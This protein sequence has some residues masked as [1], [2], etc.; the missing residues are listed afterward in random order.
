MHPPFSVYIFG[1]STNPF[2]TIK[3]RTIDGVD[4]PFYRDLVNPDDGDHYDPAA[5][6]VPDDYSLDVAPNHQQC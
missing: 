6:A 4:L 1:T 3:N 2:I 5:L